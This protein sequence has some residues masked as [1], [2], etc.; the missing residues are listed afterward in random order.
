MTAG[1]DPSRPDYP[2][3]GDGQPTETERL[4]PLPPRIGA[5]PTAGPPHVPQP[6]APTHLPPPA[7]A[8]PAPGFPPGSFPQPSYPAT[9]TFPAGGSYPQTSAFPAAGSYGPTGSPAAPYSGAAAPTSGYLAAGATPPYSTSPATPTTAA[10]K[11]GRLGRI[12]FLIALVLL[13]VVAAQA[14]LIFRLDQR[15]SAAN[16]ALADSRTKQNARIDGLESRTQELEK[17]AGANIDTTAVADAVLPSVFRVKT[18]FGIGTG[19]AFGKSAPQGGGTDLMTNFHVIAEVWKSG[20]K[21]ATIQH[22]DQTFSVKVIRVDEV[23]DLAILH[24]DESFPRLVAAS[25]DA[26]PGLPILVVGA[27]LGLENTVTTGVVSAARMTPDGARLQ[28]SA[29]INPGNSG[30]PVVNA[31][32]EVVGIATEKAPNGEGLGFAIPISTVCEAFGTC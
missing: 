4:G 8:S 6:P 10:P 28:F 16:S 7:V 24:T 3:P 20:S 17:K 29:P 23:R 5:Q 30:G 21:A 2:Q 12:A 15:L 22:K 31:Q 11:G 9:G 13:L 27:P 14:Y 1:Y 18:S 26:K 25:A 19:F 32:K